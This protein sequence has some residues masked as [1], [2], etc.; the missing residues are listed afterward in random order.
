MANVLEWVDGVAVVREQAEADL[1]PFD[2]AAARA[3][4]MARVLR[5]CDAKAGAVTSRYV[6][7]E[8]A[9]WPA[10]AAGARQI[11]AGGDVPLLIATEATALGVPPATLAGWIVTKAEAYETIIAGLAAVRQKAAAQIELAATQEEIQA[12]LTE[13]KAELEM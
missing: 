4:A 8:V 1:P 12:A 2:V 11:V 6:A 3:S 9:A 5:W 7:A 13:V 10:K